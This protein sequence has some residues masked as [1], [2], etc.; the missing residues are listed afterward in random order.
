MYTLFRVFNTKIQKLESQF[1]CWL[2]VSLFKMACSM[3]STHSKVM[4]NQKETQDGR[5][6]CNLITFE[7]RSIS[8]TIAFNMVELHIHIFN[9]LKIRLNQ[10]NCVY[11][12]YLEQWVNHYLTQ[13]FFPHNRS[14]WSHT[15]DYFLKL[16]T[17]VSNCI[18]SCL[19]GYNFSWTASCWRSGTFAK[20]NTSPN[21]SR[22][23]FRFSVHLLIGFLLFLLH[24]LCIPERKSICVRFYYLIFV[25]NGYLHYLLYHYHWRKLCRTL[26]LLA[27]SSRET[28]ILPALVLLILLLGVLLS[29]KFTLVSSCTRNDHIHHHQLIRI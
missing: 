13:R 29:G 4:W 17:K 21:V 14:F 28:I 11:W 23:L 24:Y 20:M 22:W 27:S 1:I 7:P 15:V 5:L 25:V 9:Q 6:R 10:F 8:N 3:S 18:F 2:A 16:I 12:L 19:Y 26:P